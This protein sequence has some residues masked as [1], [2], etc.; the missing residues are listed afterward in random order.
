MALQIV[1]NT[2]PAG[3]KITRE[4]MQKK[5]PLA[6]QRGLEV[7][8]SGIVPLVPVKTGRL[9][10]SIGDEAKDGYLEVKKGQKENIVIG[11]IGTNVPYAKAVEFGTS[12]F[13]GRFYFT[14]GFNSVISSISSVIINTLKL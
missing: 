14:R 6:V 4:L 12:R 10:G 2:I 5:G 7:A 13:S 11:V 8:R 1:K 3:V 9:K